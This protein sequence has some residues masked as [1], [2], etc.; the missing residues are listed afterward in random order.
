M[1]LLLPYSKCLI[2]III[3]VIIIKNI[4]LV[5]FNSNYTRTDIHMAGVLLPRIG[6]KNYDTKQIF[7]KMFCGNF[8]F[9]PQTPQKK[10][11]T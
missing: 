9:L 8:W 3:I 1:Q 4:G 7:Q 5:S 10:D 11:V 6:A 2:I